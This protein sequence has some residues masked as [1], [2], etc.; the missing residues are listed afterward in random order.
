MMKRRK[1]MNS[2]K[3]ILASN[4]KNK[5]R[6]IKEILTPLGYEVVSQSEAGINIEVE[7]TGRTFQENAQLKAK[8]IF[9]QTHTAVIADDSGLEVEYLNGAPGVYSHRYAGEN[10]TDADRYNKLLN[11]LK[12][13]PDEK[14]G[15][16]FVCV[17]CYID[18]NGNEQFARGECRGKIGYEPKG[19][20]GFGYDP[21]FM[22]GDKS[23]AEISA[24]EKNKISHRAKAL[25]KLCSILK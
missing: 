25:E 24:D 16:A 21:V 5:L 15:A 3:V 18:E 13:V 7:E 12:D 17:I 22:C 6:E 9:D 19:E 1:K 11:E 10:A 23:F 8:A 20:N 14:R 4:N 2:K